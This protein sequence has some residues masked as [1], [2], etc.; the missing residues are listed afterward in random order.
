M[1]SIPPTIAADDAAYRL[2]SEAIALIE[3]HRP[4]C[5]SLLFDVLDRLEREEAPLPP[6]Q[7]QDVQE[8]MRE[9]VEDLA[10]ALADYE[11]RINALA[12]TSRAP[13]SGDRTQREFLDRNE[14][15]RGMEGARGGR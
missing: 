12:R 6:P 2:V 3:G 15:Y 5:R 1:G 8:D 11:D 14:L 9:L 13:V 4:S 7:P 10:S